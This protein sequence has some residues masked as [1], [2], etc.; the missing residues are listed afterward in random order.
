M[1][2]FF[3][4]SLILVGVLLKNR[5]EL[6]L[7]AYT[8][9]QTERQAE[10]YAMLA[11]ARLQTGVDD[12]RHI[13]I[14]IEEEPE[15][16]ENVLSV[17]ASDDE[18][19]QG[20]LT[21]DGE[22]LYGD[23]L[24]AME[25]EGIQ[26]SF[27]GNTSITFVEGKGLLF[28][29]PVF[30][31][32]NVKYVLYR[33]YPTSAIREMFAIECYDDLGELCVA[34]RSGQIIIPFDGVT[35][36]ELVWFQSDDMLINYY[37]MHREMEVSVAVARSFSTE[38][39][40]MILFESEVPNTDYVVMGYVPKKV[41][42]EG[43]E[44]I[45]LLVTWVFGLL[46]LLVLIGAVY[47]G[48]ATMK[49]QESEALKKAKAE[50]EEASRAKS[51]FL[52]NMSHEIRTP[53]NAVLG[54][55]EMILR[56]AEKPAIINYA[57][58]IKNA[59]SILLGLVNDVLDFS[60]IEA[61]K[62][63]II[64][65][66]YDLSVL[67][68]TMVEM[69]HSRADEKGILL[70]LDF[71][72]ELPKRLNGDE[73]RIRQVLAN[74]LTNAVK[75]TQEGSVTFSMGFKRIPGEADR[76]LLQVA[77]KD[78]G[79]GIKEEDIERLF[80]EFERI[81][82]K[83]NRNIEGTGLGLNITK[84]LLDLMGSSLQVRSKYGKGS[85]FYF[86][87]EQKVLDWE[88]LGDYEAAYREQQK[89]R[90]Q[91]RETFTAPKAWALMVDDNPMNLMVF[92]SLLKRTQVN[93]ETGN[94]GD[95]GIAMTKRKA[96]DVIFLDHMMPGK[97][98]I[99][100]L[101]EIRKDESN[102]NRNTPI[103]CLTANAI[104]GAREEYLAAGFN[105][106]LSKP[107][108]NEKLE[109]MMMKYLPPEKVTVVRVEETE[110][111]AE[112]RTD[113]GTDEG[114]EEWTD[115][116]NKAGKEHS[117]GYSKEYKGKNGGI[118]EKTGLK[119]SG[120]ID[121]KTGLKNSGG[122]LAYKEMLKVFLASI[123][124]TKKELNGYYEAEDWKNYT[125]RI[126]ALKS[127]ARIIGAT[128]FGEEAQLLENAGKEAQAAKKPENAGKEAQAAKEPED[129]GKEAQAAKK[130]ENAGKEAQA[131][132]K[133]ENVGKAGGVEYIREHWA[134]FMEEYENVR[135]LIEEI[136]SDEDEEKEDLNK[137]EAESYLVEELFEELKDAADEED[138]ERI[139]SLFENM[140]GYRIPKGSAKLYKKVKKAAE[141]GDYE[142]IC[143]LLAVK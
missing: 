140:E 104:A 62:L 134:P 117:K 6:L 23:A 116:G 105:D 15:Q 142:G 96:Y 78:T 20:L 19:R 76:V 42:S 102:P 11:A 22:A 100:T 136:L 122:Q 81:E 121:E 118:D 94:D 119:N 21:I 73:V 138:D 111:E 38:R 93:V 53:I 70:Q 7:D 75:Y 54:M 124:S 40:E 17:L 46:M 26:S 61:G 113:Q 127:S 82:E 125:V 77:V 39:G 84:N 66:D 64:P 12:L 56:E 52:A 114:N 44:K 31:G 143:R 4:C 65:V 58:S 85:T 8:E 101:Q 112:E 47:L 2:V 80:S 50:A 67:L 98:G 129:A 107:I 34:T 36:D 90:T 79:M 13:A 87:L 91:Y 14:G 35:K 24:S 141:A 128:A 32:L 109:E 103:I 59:G 86:T 60:K 89:N 133:P 137:R 68:N 120:G 27:R 132:K 92:Q 29:C 3:A 25:F 41:A 33:L 95:E 1:V 51:D 48:N 5:M 130:P 45:G 55:N 18:I 37:S 69:M 63:E 97:D 30:H 123:D 16:L 9:N 108:D 88:P 74:I 49:L 139:Q 72:P 99:E 28:T 10:S 131:A 43:I 106:Y 126:H 57:E 83:K 115:T 71:D 110:E 135:D